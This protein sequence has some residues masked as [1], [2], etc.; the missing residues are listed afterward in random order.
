MQF[1]ICM[2]NVRTWN[3]KIFIRGRAVAYKSIAKLTAVPII[4]PISRLRKRQNVKV[5][6]RGIRSSSKIK[7]K[8]YNICNAQASYLNYHLLLEFQ[9]SLTKWISTMNITAVIITAAR[10]LLGIKKKYGVRIV[11]ASKTKIPKCN[12]M[13]VFE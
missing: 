1:P 3:V 10:Q 7:F 13:F 5:T 2:A 4:M 11:M 9:T 6:K 8:F 12:K